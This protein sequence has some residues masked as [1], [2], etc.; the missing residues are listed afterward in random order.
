MRKLFLP[1]RIV[2]AM[3][4]GVV[5]AWSPGLVMARLDAASYWPHAQNLLA[6]RW[7]IVAFFSPLFAYGVN[8]L[9]EVRCS[10]RRK[11][12]RSIV[13]AVIGHCRLAPRNSSGG[14][15]YGNL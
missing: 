2:I 13:F 9:K 12:S 5:L 10:Q 4:V 7:F 14:V 11:A 1:I 15:E 3:A 8:G 6:P